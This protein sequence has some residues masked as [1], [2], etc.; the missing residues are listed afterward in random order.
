MQIPGP[1]PT[2]LLAALAAALVLT[3]CS[4]EP[5]ADAPEVAAAI[6]AS[7]TDHPEAWR[8][9]VI[10]LGFDSCDP[11][12][13]EELIRAGKL[14]NFARMRREGAHGELRS[15]TPLLSPVIWTT[16]ATG[17]APERHG[18]L[19]FVTD[20]PEGKRPVSSN[21]RQAD[22][23][24]E[25][26]AAAGDPADRRPRAVWAPELLDAVKRERVTVDDIP[27]ERLRAFV[28][29]SEE[30]Y[31]AAYTT[32]YAD[33]DN[34]LGNLRLVMADAETYRALGQRLYRERRP[35]LFAAYFNAMDALSHYFIPYAPPRMPHV[36]EDHYLRYR[37]VIAA[38]YMW[39]DSVLGEYMDL[40]DDDTTVL[41]VSDHGFKHGALRT[42]ESSRFE[43]RT[44]AAWHRAYGVL[45]AWG[46]GVR[47]GHR[48]R[49]ASVW[50]IA[51]TTLAALRCPVPEDMPGDV[52]GDLF[53]DGLPHATVPTWFGDRRR[54]TVAAL[55]A[56]DTPD[57]GEGA[58][59]LS[60][61]D[62]E[63]LAKLEGLGYVSGSRDDPV[64][65]TMNLVARLLAV[66]RFDRAIE[67][68]RAT[69]AD[70][71]RGVDPRALLALCRAH[72]HHAEALR[73]AGRES[74]AER[75]FRLAEEALVEAERSMPDEPGTLLLRARLARGLGDPDSAEAWAR[76]AV[77]R[78]PLE[79]AMHN[80]LAE[81]LYAQAERA[82]RE[83]RPEQAKAYE[84]EALAA[85][86]T[87]LRREPRQFHARV[88]CALLLLSALPAPDV[89]RE[90]QVR[91]V[92]RNAED[93]LEHLDAAVDLITESPTAHNNR[94][95]AQLRLGNIA[96]VANRGP[97][98]QERLL[99]ALASAETALSIQPE[100]A[101]GWANKAYVLWKL[102]RMDEALAAAQDA[103]RV[104]PSYRF[105]PKF[106]FALVEA[107][108]SLPA[109]AAA[110]QE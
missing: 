28:D 78:D 93:A 108:H 23:V 84:D 20:T 103:R 37:D 39:H 19:D 11:D 79:P 3:G 38:T 14:P 110:E 81:I 101:I 51:P 21:M 63:E 91:H 33:P 36:P 105:D 53:E 57:V 64:S 30:E 5:L 52:L 12:L 90:E 97:E 62:L 45:Y 26:V 41:V 59:A 22:S 85:Y 80:E 49:G 31:R 69:L 18:I 60:A 35:R 2:V 107:G 1:R 88:R 17:M 4:A 86:R 65:T 82:R 94:A 44:G 83:G 56:A 87:S 16:V 34:L 66:R 73:A 46:G 76:K 70:P 58:A 48:V 75:E 109:P 13:V 55:R 98:A 6:R 99:D 67:L 68:L 72:T 100:Y 92:A 32:T 77:E 43:A 71:S 29:V 24:W 102:G 25:L 96:L 47:P 95:I 10:L 54:E 27:L 89:P 61:Q 74:E 104:D 40:A 15:L 50:D 106:V 9:K 42:E 8:R 7:R